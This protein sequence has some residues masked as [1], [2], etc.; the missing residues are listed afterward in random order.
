MRSYPSWIAGL[1]YP[2]PDGTN[3]GWYCKGLRPGT[4]LNLV[5]EPDNPHSESGLAVAVTHEGRHLGYIPSRHEWVGEAIDEDKVVTCI[6][7]RIEIS[8]WLFRRAR[9]VGLILSVARRTREPVAKE[10]K[11][12]RDKAA[13]AREKERERKAGDLCIDG[14]KILAHIAKSDDNLSAEELAA[15]ADYIAA[16]LQS[17]DFAADGVLIEKLLGRA[18]GL[19]VPQRAFVRATNIVAKDR[20]HFSQV[21]A[22]ALR[23]VDRPAPLND[24]E[25]AALQKLQA[26]GK[27][28]GWL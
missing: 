5:R 23:M 28:N 13:E 27:A 17:A 25:I 9:F 8:G 2:G 21:L 14:L 6:V 11:P 19:T 15:Q 26:A 12:K 24:T 4:M 7:D 22:A 16:R 1:K 18:Q 3:R 10:P 20:Q